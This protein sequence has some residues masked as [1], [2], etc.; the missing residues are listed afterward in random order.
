MTPLTRPLSR[1]MSLPAAP[2]IILTQQLSNICSLA[3]T[4]EK[5]PVKMGRERTTRYVALLIMRSWCSVEQ[6]VVC[7]SCSQALLHVVCMLGNADGSH[8]WEIWALIKVFALSVTQLSRLLCWRCFCSL[9]YFEV[10]GGLFFCSTAFVCQRCV[11]EM[12]T[13]HQHGRTPHTHIGAPTFSAGRTNSIKTD[14]F[15]SNK[16]LQHKVPHQEEENVSLGFLCRCT[17]ITG[18]VPNH[19]DRSLGPYLAWSTPLIPK[20]RFNDNEWWEKKK[21]V[22]LARGNR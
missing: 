9:P 11:R 7:R 2:S 17:G 20:E 22:I 18:P 15:E 13:K 21:R 4:D 1:R 5:G 8:E 14:E 12:I 19:P 3:L 6:S 16:N 10:W